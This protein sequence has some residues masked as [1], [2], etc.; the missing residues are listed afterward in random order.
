[1]LA[2]GVILLGICG[3][4]LTQINTSIKLTKLFSS[5]AEIIKNYEWLEEN[6]GPLVPMEVVLRFD[7]NRSSL[8]ML[9][10]A[11]LVDRIQKSLKEI[12]EVGNTMSAVTF[13]PPLEGKKSGGFR[14]TIRDV[15]N[16][17]FEAHREEYIEGGFLAMDG[18]VELWRINARVKRST[19]SIMGCFS[20]SCGPRSSRCCSPSGREF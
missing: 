3:Y 5:S 4:G 12:D 18:D 15:F 9:E 7:N 20:T 8:T 1:M 11:E 19:T 17:R 2:A 14:R 10:R 16:R 6:L 13:A